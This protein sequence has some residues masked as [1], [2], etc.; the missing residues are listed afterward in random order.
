M[1]S[2]QRRRLIV[3]LVIVGVLAV[4][5]IGVG[6]LVVSLGLPLWVGVVAGIVAVVAVAAFTLLNLA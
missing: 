2:D 4:V 1:S 6:W 5:G 3:V